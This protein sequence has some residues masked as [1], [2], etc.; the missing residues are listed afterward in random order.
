MSSFVA[1]AIRDTTFGQQIGG[2]FTNEPSSDQFITSE[3][4]YIQRILITLPS[5]GNTHTGE[6]NFNMQDD[7]SGRVPM[8][9]LFQTYQVV[10][11]TGFVTTYWP[12]AYTTAGAEILLLAAPYSRSPY[13]SNGTTPGVNISGFNLANLPG[14]TTKLVIGDALQNGMESGNAIKIHNGEPMY[15]MVTRSA[16]NTASADNGQQPSAKPLQLQFWNGADNT[17]WQIGIWQFEILSSNFIGGLVEL[18]IYAKVAI[19]FEGIRWG[20][21]SWPQPVPTQSY[22]LCT[23]CGHKTVTKGENSYTNTCSALSSRSHRSWHGGVCSGQKK[24]LSLF[25]EI[26]TPEKDKLGNLYAEISKGS[27]M[28]KCNNNKAKLRSSLNQSSSCQVQE[29]HDEEGQ[30]S[31]KT[32]SN[33]E[34]AS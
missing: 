29:I 4:T 9:N 17:T 23:N 15:S 20:T 6:I 25:G 19:K 34:D 27:S 11:W 3:F 8:A 22:L 24:P 13:L 18:N 30:G 16:G 26:Q 21:V 31:I 10:G 14:C 33:S 7:L 5:T 28:G 12:N 32:S 2:Y 1:D